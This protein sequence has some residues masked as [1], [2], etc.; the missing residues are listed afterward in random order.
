MMI[1]NTHVLPCLLLLTHLSIEPEDQESQ[2]CDMV[3][4][5]PVRCLFL[6]DLTSRQLKISYGGFK[7]LEIY[8]L[9]P[10]CFFKNTPLF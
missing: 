7:P 1:C 10:K 6:H 4:T 9:G 5:A 2:N 8:F 3:L